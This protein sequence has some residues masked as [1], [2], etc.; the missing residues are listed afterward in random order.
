MLE[1]L[2]EIMGIPVLGISLDIL[3]AMCMMMVILLCDRFFSI[4]EYVIH[5]FG[6]LRK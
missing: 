3:F 4:V 2:Q 5:L 6:G 1:N